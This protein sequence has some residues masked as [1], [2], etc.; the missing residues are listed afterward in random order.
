MD[1]AATT[2]HP[3][4]QVCG[5]HGEFGYKIKGEMQWFCAKHRLA[6]NYADAR[7]PAP[8]PV[9]LVRYEAARHALAEAHRV[10]EVKDIRDKAVAMQTYAKLAKDETLIKHATD[11]RMRAEIRAGQLLT[12]MKE[13]GERDAGQG[14]DR[15]SRSPAATVK[16]DDLGITK[17][18][19]SRWQRLAALP[20]DEQE[21]KIE[22]AKRREAQP[23]PLAKIADPAQIE[24]NLHYYIRRTNNFARVFTKFFKASTFDPEAQKRISTAIDRMIHK[25]RSTQATLTSTEKS[26]QDDLIDQAMASIRAMREANYDTW[27]KFDRLYQKARETLCEIGF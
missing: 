21:E 8:E 13:H 6:Q 20:P 10:D 4:C 14:G 22:A 18:Q 19:S 11:I 24:D 7:V 1:T 9:S 15:K 27:A 3:H 23:E 12:E 2:E 17:T 25:W 5:E 16:L 26:E